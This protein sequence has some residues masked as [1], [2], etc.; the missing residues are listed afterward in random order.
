MGG[1]K[2][3]KLW[4]RSGASQDLNQV[5]NDPVRAR[6]LEHVGCGAVLPDSKSQ[7]RRDVLLQSGLSEQSGQVACQ[8]IAAAAL[9]QMGI[10]GAI[11]INLAIGAAD[12]SLV[13]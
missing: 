8:R 7:Q 5:F 9:G 1:S 4:L 3:S 11:D 2:G 6:G 10:A 12:Q 13:D